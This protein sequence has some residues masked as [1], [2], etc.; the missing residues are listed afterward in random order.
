MQP[1]RSRDIRP[2]QSLEA[3]PLCRAEALCLRLIF[4]GRQ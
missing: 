3:L 1:P 2:D 4:A